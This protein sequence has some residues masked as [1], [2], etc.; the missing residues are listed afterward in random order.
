M[1]FQAVLPI[2]M[3]FIHLPQSH[4]ITGVDRKMKITE[5]KERKHI[6]FSTC[7]G[8]API[9][10]N[11]NIVSIIPLRRPIKAVHEN[12]PNEKIS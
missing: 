5:D 4:Q 1:R 9:Y 2:Y 7:Q 10:I 8:S 11:Q 12:N 3:C 6:P